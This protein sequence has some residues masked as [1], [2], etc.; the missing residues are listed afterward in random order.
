MKLI[1]QLIIQA[2]VFCP[3]TSRL[4]TTKTAVPDTVY[5]SDNLIIIRLSAHVY[6]HV[7]F[8]K[9]EAFGKVPC[10]GMLVTDKKEALVF[11]TPADD[12]SSAE[13]VNWIN[14][15]L[16]SKIK[17]VVPT[18]FHEDCLGGLKTFHTNGI[19]SYATYNTIALA[20]SRGFSIPAN[21]FKDSKTFSVGDKQ[22][23][24]AFPGE[25]H[26]KDNIV[27]YV[28]HDKILFGGCLIKEMNAGKGNLADANV[29]AWPPTVQQVQK[30]FP[31]VKTVIPGHGLVG[32]K[33]LLDYTIKL[34]KD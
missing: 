11:D 21:G 8:F 14:N 4:Q 12:G 30:K 7:S 9:S 24:A 6:L 15:E 20:K 17:A 25:G 2:I 18:H 33:S 1:F 32:D 26:T 22:V 28:P 29:K 34:F 10:N 27:A 3:S 23:L 5:Q 13:L 31:D 19:T 16:D